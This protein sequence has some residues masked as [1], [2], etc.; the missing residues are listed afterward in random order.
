MVLAQ[1]EKPIE[2]ALKNMAF[3]GIDSDGNAGVV[4]ERMA[5]VLLRCS[6][7]Q[8]DP[9]Q[10]QAAARRR[11]LARYLLQRASPLVDASTRA[12]EA[13]LTHIST[14]IQLE[15]QVLDAQDAIYRGALPGGSAQPA[16]ALPGAVGMQ[17]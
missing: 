1:F 13:D 17:Y 3:R 8:G 2:I 10:Q 7:A 6:L 14:L 15:G 5:Q 11:E 9:E 4:F 12:G 16:P